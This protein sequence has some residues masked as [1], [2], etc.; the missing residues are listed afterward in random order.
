MN[1]ILVRPCFRR[2]HTWYILLWHHSSNTT[3]SH[4]FHWRNKDSYCFFCRVCRNLRTGYLPTAVSLP[5]T[6][7]KYANTFY[8]SFNYCVLYIFC[9]WGND[10]S[11]YNRSNSDRDTPDDLWN[12]YVSRLWNRRTYAQTSDRIALFRLH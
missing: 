6:W 5:A 2:H 7:W 1:T 3:Y 12:H 10:D 4:L 8:H 11:N 9:V